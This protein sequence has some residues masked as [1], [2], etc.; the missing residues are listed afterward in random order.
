MVGRPLRARRLHLHHALTSSFYRFEP[1]PTTVG[2]LVL[3]VLSL[4]L[5]GRI[6]LLTVGAA[7]CT[8][9]A[10][11]PGPGLYPSSKEEV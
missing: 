11:D 3:S 7:S 6:F 9:I 8:G 4:F 5:D 10:T 2:S 1:T